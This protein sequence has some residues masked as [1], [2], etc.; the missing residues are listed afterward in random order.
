MPP[1]NSC[2]IRIATSTLTTS[3]TLT[4][5]QRKLRVGVNLRAQILSE[6]LAKDEIAEVKQNSPNKYE[7][8]VS[9]VELTLRNSNETKI[10]VCRQIEN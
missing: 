10:E 7:T 9:V 3:R 6:L 8:S 5:E 1:L 4:K 2:G